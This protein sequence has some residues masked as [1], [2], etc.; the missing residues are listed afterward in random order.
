MGEGNWD[1]TGSNEIMYAQMS[2]QIFS[3]PES[4][5]HWISI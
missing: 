2:F 4:S 3:L 1:S 5:F